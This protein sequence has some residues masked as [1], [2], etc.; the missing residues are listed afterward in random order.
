LKTDYDQL[1]RR[2][3]IKTALGATAACGV[4]TPLRSLG[5]EIGAHVG[6]AVD[7]GAEDEAGEL[8]LAGELLRRR[9]E[10]AAECAGV[11]GG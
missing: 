5:A 1:N 7:G 8:G 11:G 9:K 10:D 3:F 6:E 4:H 2:V